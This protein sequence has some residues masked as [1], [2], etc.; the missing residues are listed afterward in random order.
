MLLRMDE[1]E[2]RRAFAAHKALCRP[3]EV[4]G[5]LMACTHAIAW[6]NDHAATRGL[7]TAKADCLAMEE[8]NAGML[9]ADLERRGLT[10]PI[11]ARPPGE[12]PRPRLP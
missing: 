3:E 10:L 7:S 5:W 12:R 2:R 9:K 1:S 8:A 11:W 6:W 4:A